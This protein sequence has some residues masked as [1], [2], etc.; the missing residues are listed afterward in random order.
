MGQSEP[1]GDPDAKVEIHVV[2]TIDD[3][4]K[5]FVIRGI[6]YMGDQSCPYA[7]EFDGNDECATHLIA[8][9]DGEPAGT[10]RIRYFGDF[11]KIERV[12]VRREY[13]IYN[14]GFRMAK[15]AEGIGARK[16]FRRVYGTIQIRLTRYWSR[17]GY[18]PLQKARL[19]FSDHEYVPM[20]GDL[21]EATDPLGLDSD[22]LV[23]VRPEGDW[24]RPGILDLSAARGA[25]NPVART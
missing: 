17:I 9:V 15:Y 2:S 21:P 13:R 4:I 12:A 24:D 23:L 5:A 10:L 14:L 16:G 3:R 1:A 20:V 8:T 6:V 7:E 18:R 11:I 25:T 19:V 22:D